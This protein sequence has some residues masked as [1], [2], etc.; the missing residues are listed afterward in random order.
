[1]AVHFV[2]EEYLKSTPVLTANVD[3]KSIVPFIPIA[4]DIY[5]T[6]ILGLN[7]YNYLL[8]K[9][10]AQTL[11]ANEEILV[12]KIKPVVAFRAGSE[13]LPFQTNFISNKGPQKQNSDYSNPVD[14]NVSDKLKLRLENISNHYAQRLVN[15]L[16]ENSELFPGYT[17]NNSTDI[18]PSTKSPFNFGIAFPDVGGWSTINGVYY[19]PNKYN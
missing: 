6:K 2:S 10:R 14:E 11:N 18:S 19:G 13:S 16:I 8:D 3:P 5:L 15:Y 1:M 7:F 4:E 17:A 12:E 9:Y